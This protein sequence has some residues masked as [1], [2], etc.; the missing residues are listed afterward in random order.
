MLKIVGQR[1]DG[2]H[3]L[4]T[5]F[6][7]IDLCDWLTF[8]PSEDGCVRMDGLLAGV[9]EE[10]NLVVRAAKKLKQCSGYRGGV[11]IGIEKNIPMGGGLGGGSSN[12]ATTLVVLN[13]M[14]GLDLSV[15]QLIDLGAGLGADI[16]IFV[17]GYS[18]WA[19][20]VGEKLEAMQLPEK[21]FVIIKP[22]C[23]VETKR[24]FSAKN[25]TRNSKSITISGFSSGHFVNDCLDVVKSNYPL[26]DEALNQLNLFGE[27]RLTGTG[28]CVFAEYRD[29]N[30][31][32]E[33][34]ASLSEELLVF[35]AKGLNI[36]PLY[37]QIKQTN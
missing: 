22:N 37:R 34:A 35:V 14:W 13:K 10:Q 18:A 7:L 21:W 29:K 3:L 19:E 24:I 1:P 4:Q 30:K 6:Q 2:Y 27:A 5:V 32:Q 20:G 31:A 28:A 15:S 26:I 16:P 33:V 17:F 23:H 9:A 36:S 11:S 8:K 12:A 25:L